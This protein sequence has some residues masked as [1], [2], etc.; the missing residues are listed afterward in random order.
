MRWKFVEYTTKVLGGFNWSIVS[1]SEFWV[2]SCNQTHRNYFS[3]SLFEPTGAFYFFSN[4]QSNL[5]RSS[6]IFT[7][8]LVFI[9]W[10]RSF[11]NHCIRLE[12]ETG[13]TLCT[14]E[15]LVCINKSSLKYQQFLE[16]T[17]K[18]MCVSRLCSIKVINLCIGYAARLL[19]WQANYFLF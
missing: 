16:K 3:T 10:V 5:S 2:L 19:F 6:C 13:M 8:S 1:F 17:I 4:G 11:N 18:C 12:L 7:T 14:D 9:Y 15:V